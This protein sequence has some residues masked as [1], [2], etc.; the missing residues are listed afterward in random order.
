MPNARRPR[1]YDAAARSSEKRAEEGGLRVGFPNFGLA[2][3]EPKWDNQGDDDED[4]DK[5]DDDEEMMIE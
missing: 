1:T 5:E 3:A 4:N 2:A